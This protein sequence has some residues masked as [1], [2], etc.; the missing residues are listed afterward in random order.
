[1][2]WREAICNIGSRAQF[3]IFDLDLGNF[4]E[5]GL[6]IGNLALAGFGRFGVMLHI[7]S[8]E[9]HLWL[10]SAHRAVIMPPVVSKMGVLG[11]FLYILLIY[12]LFG[13]DLGNP[14]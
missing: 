7:S 10:K 11:Q 2:G 12:A 6:D 3:Q 8:F 14:V 13:L 4:L 9:V 1:M 5:F